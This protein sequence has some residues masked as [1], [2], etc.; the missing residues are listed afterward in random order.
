[1]YR[2]AIKRAAK[3]ESK[4]TRTWVFLR[5]RKPRVHWFIIAHYILLRTW[6]DRHRELCSSR[7]RGL[8]LGAFI[9]STRK[10]RIAYQPFVGLNCN[11]NRFDSSPVGYERSVLCLILLL[12]ALSTLATIVAV[13]CDCRRIR[14]LYSRQCGQGLTAPVVTFL[15]AVRGAAITMNKLSVKNRNHTVISFSADRTAASSA[16]GYHSNSLT[17]CFKFLLS[18]TARNLGK[19]MVNIWLRMWWKLA[20]YTFLDHRLYWEVYTL[21]WRVMKV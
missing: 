2:L 10:N 19:K 8:R 21:L 12:F 9:N 17:S 4:K 6:E 16:I 3:N 11:R 13:F 7:L 15:F 5:H 20:C 14:R 1:M 18:V